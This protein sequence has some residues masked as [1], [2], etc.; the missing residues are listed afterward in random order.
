MDEKLKIKWECCLAEFEE[1][2]A[3]QSFKTWFEPIKPL[4]FEN[5]TLLLVIPSPFFYEWIQEHYEPLLRKVIVTHF[6]KN[7][8]IRYETI[9]E[10]Q[11]YEKSYKP[12]IIIASEAMYRKVVSELGQQPNTIYSMP[13]REFENLV[14]YILEDL[15][16]RVH[17]TPRSKDGGKDIIANF[18]TP[19]GEDCI[20]YVECKRFNPDRPVGIEVIRNLYGVIELERVHLGMVVTTSR[21][22]KGAI[23]F[24]K[25]L[26][27]KVSLKN[28]NNLIEWIRIINQAS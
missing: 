11:I 2:V 4:S 6:D 22:T 17:F 20:C 12:E 15:G 27:R 26:T 23:D 19:T 16:Y 7:V 14:A 25:N 3:L 28:Y 1:I 9:L 24:E 10:N 21:F 18:Q 8:R 5:R 13:P